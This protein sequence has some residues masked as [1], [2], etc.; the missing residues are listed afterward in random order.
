[1]K[2]ETRVILQFD[3]LV[4]GKVAQTVA[5]RATRLQ[6]VAKKPRGAK[7]RLLIPG[8]I[9]YASTLRSLDIVT[10][11]TDKKTGKPKHWIFRG[12]LRHAEAKPVKPVKPV[13]PTK[14]AKVAKA[15][16]VPRKVRRHRR[17]HRVTVA[18]VT[19][20]LAS[21]AP[22]A[23]IPPSAAVPTAAA[24]VLTP[25]ATAELAAGAE[26]GSPTAAGQTHARHARKGGAPAPGATT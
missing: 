1:M 19:S 12:K 2:H 21:A 7:L 17:H 4:A 16:K 23:P 10:G 8:L 11:P 25:G 6:R 18:P 14:G 15:A 13:K 3:L 22:P 26:P 24:P 20:A 9:L 5:K